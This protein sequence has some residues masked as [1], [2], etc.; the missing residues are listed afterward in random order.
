MKMRGILFTVIT[1]ILLF[2][3]YKVYSTTHKPVN[4]STIFSAKVID[5]IQLKDKNIIEVVDINNINKTEN[6]K[7]DTPIFSEEKATFTTDKYRKIN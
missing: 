2:T 7:M 3:G 1:M 4:H 5:K 6:G